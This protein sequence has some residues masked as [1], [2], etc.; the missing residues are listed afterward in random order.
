MKHNWEYKSF[1]DVAKTVSPT[2]KVEKS[3]YEATGLFPIV[4]Q[5]DSYISGYWNNPNDLTHHDKP[6]I[7]FGDH[8]RVL[9]YVDFDFVVGADGV[10]IIKPND[11]VN[12]KF[13]YHYLNWYKIPSLGYSRH[14]KLIKKALFPIPSLVCQK[15]IASELDLISDIIVDCREVLYNLDALAKSLFYDYFGDHISNPKGWE[16]AKIGT[17]ASVQTGATPSREIEAYFQGE[18]SWIKTT[19]VQNCLITETEE[20]IS[21]EALKNSNCKIFPVNTILIAMYGQ[22]KTRGQIA[23]LGIEA[24]T[25]QACAAILP[26]VK[27]HPIFLFYFLLSSYEPLRNIAVGGNQKNL[28]LSLIKNYSIILP[29]LA[30][31]EQFAVRIE[32]IETQK[33]NVE[34]T[35]AEMQTLLDSRMD[36]WFN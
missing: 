27:I 9:K 13:L 6:V 16:T 34:A 20:H 32:Q 29:P 8:S 7:I 24:C 28:N 14:F 36:Y 17:I 22:G 26:A 4:S 3:D 1:D 18:I 31:Q 19:E 5:E 23:R 25:N 33:A 30:L 12:A 2:Y 15:R 35:I 11:N 10:K 21:E